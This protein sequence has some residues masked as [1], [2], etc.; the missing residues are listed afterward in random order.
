MPKRFLNIGRVG[1]TGQQ[2]GGVGVPEIM[3][4]Y[5]WQLRPLEQRLEVTVYDVLGVERGALARSEHKALIKKG[6]L[7]ARYI[8]SAYSAV[9]MASITWS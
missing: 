4:A 3:P 2:K 1:A 9:P 5:R 7:W 6:F 8:I